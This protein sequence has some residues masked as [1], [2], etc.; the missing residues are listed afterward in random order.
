MLPAAEPEPEALAM[1]K[2]VSFVGRSTVGAVKLLRAVPEPPA[3][4][5]E[6]K[7]VSPRESEKLTLAFGTGVPLRVTVAR[8]VTN[9]P[10]KTHEEGEVESTTSREVEE[11]TA[12]GKSR[13]VPSVDGRV[14]R[15]TPATSPETARETAPTTPVEPRRWS[16]SGSPDRGASRGS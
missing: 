6:G 2:R 4:E 9:S 8:I 14:G 13:G 1:A 15:A 12:D 3:R 7:N 16:G 5:V 11:V 10:E